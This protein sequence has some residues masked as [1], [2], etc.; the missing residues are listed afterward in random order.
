MVAMLAV[1]VALV[2]AVACQ[3]NPHAGHSHGSPLYYT[4]TGCTTLSSHAQYSLDHRPN[5]Q[6]QLR[7]EASQHT[8]GIPPPID[9]FACWTKA[10]GWTASAVTERR[11]SVRRHASRAYKRVYVTTLAIYKFKIS[12]ISE[13]DIGSAIPLHRPSLERS[14]T[15]TG[16]RRWA[17]L[18]RGLPEVRSA[19][20]NASGVF[21]T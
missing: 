16:R 13:S 18:S 17:V 3:C 2:E 9:A 11:A 12:C 10:L 4:S 19:E 15:R 14:M 7:V 8:G 6:V 21:V 1:V 5:S 20:D